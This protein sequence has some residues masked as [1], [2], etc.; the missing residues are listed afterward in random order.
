MSLGGELTLKGGLELDG[1]INGT[2]Y[3]YSG[4]GY[5]AA[6][7]SIIMHGD[8]TTGMSGLLFCSDKTSTTSINRTSDRAFI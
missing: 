4:G 8:A 6:Y 5:N 7:N 3:A 2:S 1:I